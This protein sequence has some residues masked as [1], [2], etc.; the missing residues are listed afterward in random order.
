MPA[1]PWLVAYLGTALTLPFVNALLRRIF[2]AP[3]TLG[4]E[5]SNQQARA[6]FQSFFKEYSLILL[7]G[8]VLSSA[9]WWALCWCL[10]LL[11]ARALPQADFC[12]IPELVVWSVPGLM[13]GV[14]TAW[15][16]TRLVLQRRLGSRYSRFASYLAVA[17]GID[18]RRA[19]KTIMPVG[20]TLFVVIPMV[21]FANWYVY[22]TDSTI[23]IKNVFVFGET[24][25][26]Y[27]DLESI[28]TAPWVENRSGTHRAERAYVFHFHDGSIWATGWAPERLSVSTQT[29]LAKFVARKSGVGITEVP[30]LRAG[31]F[32]SR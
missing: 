19:L 25:H 26:T 13:M 3:H 7:L 12:F 14:A 24:R 11:A 30:I 1:N 9:F 2:P 29:A 4:S 5:L 31:D 18:Q 17:N 16:P 22:F 23:V 21:F 27:Q 15:V 10:G 6:E 28:V 8:T 20:V 32:V